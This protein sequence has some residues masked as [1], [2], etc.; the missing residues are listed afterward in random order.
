MRAWL[1]ASA[2]M[3]VVRRRPGR[4][5]SRD[6]VE[7][8]AQ[9]HPERQSYSLI[10]V[11]T[12]DGTEPHSKPDVRLVVGP[13]TTASFVTEAV[14]KLP[15]TAAEQGPSE[16]LIPSGPR[17]GTCR[18]CGT[19]TEMTEEHMPPRGSFNTQRGREIALDDASAATNS[20]LQRPDGGCRAASVATCSADPATTPR[21]GGAGSTRNG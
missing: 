12:V 1:P 10:W 3:S 14:E 15:R 5:S 17:N 9:A 16:A 21:D 11:L 18:I 13:A 20:I 8:A 4:A 6:Q 2:T 19:T 7:L